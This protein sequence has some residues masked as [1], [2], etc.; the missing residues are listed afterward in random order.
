VRAC[1]PALLQVSHQA[2]AD[3]RIFGEL[4]LREPGFL[5]PGTD[6][7]GRLAT[8]V[9]I[10]AITI[11]ADGQNECPVMSRHRNCW[12]MPVPMMSPPV[13][14]RSNLRFLAQQVLGQFAFP[15]PVQRLPYH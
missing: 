4:L 10:H 1:G 6:Q 14:S 7:P 11:P 15:V 12:H 8:T 5:T 3:A 2:N 9:L 13:R